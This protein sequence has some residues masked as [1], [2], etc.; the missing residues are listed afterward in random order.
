M[1]AQNSKLKKKQHIYQENFHDIQFSLNFKPRNFKSRM[2][3][4][5]N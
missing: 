5:E 2:Q 1:Q 3:N 4:S